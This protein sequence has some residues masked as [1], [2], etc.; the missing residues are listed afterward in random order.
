MTPGIAMLAYANIHWPT[1]PVR[2]GSKQPAYPHN[3]YSATTDRQTLHARRKQ[4]P[5][6]NVAVAAGEPIGA[7]VVDIDPRSSGWESLANLEL[8]YDELPHTVTARTAGGGEHRL[9]KLPTL[10]TRLRS[11]LATG[12]D[13]LSTGRY[14]LVPPSRREDGR[15][16]EWIHSPW[17][18]EIASPPD[19]L[20]DLVVDRSASQVDPVECD[21]PARHADVTIVKNGLARAK[22][23]VDAVPGAVSGQ[24]GHAATFELAVK[25]VLGFDLNDADAYALMT[26]WNERCQPPW[27]ERDLKRKLSEARKRGRLPVGFMERTR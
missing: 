21:G 5:D 26:R 27:T 4:Y 23:Y 20:V 10:A 22:A 19:W 7:F 2:R 13:I 14:F 24:G 16:Y 18:T 6:A 1:L 8:E 15:T 25:L 12:I 9:Y 11:K 17:T 3:V